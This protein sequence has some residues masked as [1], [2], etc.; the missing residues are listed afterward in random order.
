M[1]LSTVLSVLKYIKYCTW[2]FR[3]SYVYFYPAQQI[4]GLAKYCTKYIMCLFWS[5]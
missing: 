5:Y 4:L 1:E 3:R 2:T